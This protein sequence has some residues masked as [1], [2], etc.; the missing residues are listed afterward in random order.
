M[1]ELSKVPVGQ[2]FGKVVVL[3][4]VDRKIYTREKDGKTIKHKARMVE[5]RCD[6]GRIFVTRLSN[7]TKQ[8]KVR[9]CGCGQ[10]KETPYEICG[11][12]TKIYSSNNKIALIDTEDLPKIVHFRFWCDKKGYFRCLRR[13]Y[14]IALHRIITNCPKG[15]YVDHINHNPSDN[16]KCNLRICEPWQNA[17]NKKNVKGI[18]K[19]KY[20][21]FVAEIRFNNQRIRLG[22]FKTEAEALKARKEAE[23]KYFGEFRYKGDKENALATA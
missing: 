17:L 2:R 8:V 20:N 19:T 15:L 12:V 22:S 5:C 21:T 6:C 9:S 18:W 14:R 23:I 11:E 7:F 10:N 13:K 1:K 3:R 4:E 16:R